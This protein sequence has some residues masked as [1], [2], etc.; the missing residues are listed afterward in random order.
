LGEAR[1]CVEALPARRTLARRTKSVCRN[2]AVIAASEELSTLKNKDCAGE[3]HFATDLTIDQSKNLFAGLR[4]GSGSRPTSSTTAAATGTEVRA[5]PRSRS[6]QLNSPGSQGIR[7]VK[8]AI[9]RGA[10]RN[11]VPGRADRAP[12]DTKLGG[13]AASDAG[14]RAAALELEPLHQDAWI[15]TVSW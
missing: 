6:S 3:E 5:A 10:Q 15:S 7:D 1:L 13:F 8:E 4:F 11:D 12:P 2:P 14:P 9:S